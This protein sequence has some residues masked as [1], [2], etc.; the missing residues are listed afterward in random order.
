MVQVGRGLVAN[1]DATDAIA[2]AVP[3]SLA[4]PAAGG[5]SVGGSVVW[6]TAI[7]PAVVIAVRTIAVRTGRGAADDGSGGQAADH[8]SGDGATTRLRGGGRCDRSNRHSRGCSKGGQGSGHGVT[9]RIDTHDKE[10]P[11]PAS[12]FPDNSR[13]N[14]EVPAAQ[15]A[16]LAVRRRILRR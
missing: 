16:P 10:T 2:V 8:A 1:P 3:N 9:S 5:G 11:S 12:A 6:A 13:Q 14:A 4:A 15:R 7:I